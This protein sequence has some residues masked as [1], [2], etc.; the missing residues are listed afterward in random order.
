MI[1]I[2]DKSSI[3]HRIAMIITLMTQLTSISDDYNIHDKSSTQLT[4]ISDD[5]NINETNQC[6]NELRLAMIIALMANQHT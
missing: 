3:C 4:S 1:N 5:Y 2:N 6:H